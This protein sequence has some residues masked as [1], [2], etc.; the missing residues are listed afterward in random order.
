MVE[1]S[2]QPTNYDAVPGRQAPLPEQ[3]V[4]LERLEELRQRFALPS[5]EQ[6]VAALSEALKYGDA[7]VNLLVAAMKDEALIVR[8]N[9]FNLLLGLSTKAQ[10]AI[11]NGIVMHPGDCFY[12]VYE[13]GIY[14]DDEEY[15]FID[16]LDENYESLSVVQYYED[17]D[18][19]EYQDDYYIQGYG[20]KFLSRHL[21]RD[22]A[23][24]EAELLH[25]QKILKADISI[26]PSN[27]VANF[28]IDEWCVAN[29]VSLL[30]Q[31]QDNKLAFLGIEDWQWREMEDKKFGF[32]VLKTLQNNKNVEVMG[33]LWKL[34]GIPRLAFVH[35]EKIKHRAYFQIS[36]N[37]QC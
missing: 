25:K 37:I 12:C 11:G 6:R 22:K 14:F 7:G 20:L 13:T 32:R 1:N 2:N 31:Y 17:D 19:N 8:V 35:E 29:G 15:H 16:S 34:L 5:V 27:P 36:G 4:V 21:F 30:R 26:L 3:G 28:N 18:I 23:E 10:Q 9:A 24:T 33:E